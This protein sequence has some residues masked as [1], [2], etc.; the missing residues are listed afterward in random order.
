ME[1]LSRGTL[2]GDSVGDVMKLNEAKD[3]T[4][5]LGKLI[6]IIWVV[7]EIL[8]LLPI[9]RD[10]TDPAGIK[11]SGMVLYTDAKTGCQYLS[12]PHGG[13]TPRL[14]ADGRQYGCR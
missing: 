1:N 8:L 11:R 2:H 13:I 7:S 14:G 10:D 4:R 3:Y 6:L 5:W 9:A 12:V